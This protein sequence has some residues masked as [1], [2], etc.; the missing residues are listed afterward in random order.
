MIS[1]RAPLV[2][3]IQSAYANTGTTQ[4]HQPS[5]KLSFR[6]EVAKHLNSSMKDSK[7]VPG[8]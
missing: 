8:Q 4:G 3:A 6:L 7:Q 1:P 2:D 5:C